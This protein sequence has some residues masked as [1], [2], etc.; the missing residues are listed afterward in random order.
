MPEQRLH[1]AAKHV[2]TNQDYSELFTKGISDTTNCISGC[3]Y[4]CLHSN[5]ICL[6]GNNTSSRLARYMLSVELCNLNKSITVNF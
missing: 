4:I 1:R 3:D 5:S 2:T 6:H